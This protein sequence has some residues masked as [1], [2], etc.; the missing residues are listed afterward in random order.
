MSKQKHFRSH[1]PRNAHV[2]KVNRLFNLANEYDTAFGN[3]DR[4]AMGE[5]LRREA[6]DMLAHETF[7][8]K[9]EK[10]ARE[11]LVSLMETSA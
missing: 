10:D 6:Y 1:V 2:N 3:G 4:T 7:V 9:D 11:A 5:S 8:S